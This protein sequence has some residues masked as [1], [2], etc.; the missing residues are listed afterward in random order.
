MTE[1]TA[2]LKEEFINAIK[3][4]S[5]HAKI[6]SSKVD[7][8]NSGNDWIKL[9]KSLKW[10]RIDYDG[11]SKNADSK[12]SRFIRNMELFP[13]FSISAKRRT[14]LVSIY[15]VV[16]SDRSKVETKNLNHYE[17][18][19]MSKQKS[20]FDYY[21]NEEN[22]CQVFDYDLNEYMER[23]RKE[24]G[25]FNIIFSVSNSNGTEEFLCENCNGVGEI[26]YS[27]GNYANG[28]P[29]IKTKTCP[30]C[31]G[32]GKISSVRQTVK[33]FEDHYDFYK[34]VLL[35]VISDKSHD[36]EKFEFKKK[37]NEKRKVETIFNFDTCDGYLSDDWLHTL[38]IS[39]LYQ[40]PNKII[41]DNKSQI[42][43]ELLA[44]GD[45]YKVLYNGVQ[46]EIRHMTKGDSKG[47]INIVCVLERHFTISPITVIHVKYTDS[48]NNDLETKFYAW[49][50]LLWCENCD[51]LS[52]GKLL[53]LKIKKAIS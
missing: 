26:E 12:D 18:D 8:N 31:G 38:Q 17:Y 43:N 36:D 22:L 27:A 25:S 32:K 48:Y 23:S 13:N 5:I 45:D 11:K 6:S 24:D 9:L 19:A 15:G 39:Q 46:N 29:R 37:S 10:K 40:A 28:E 52:F 53:L 4:S 41:I 7:V 34:E 47:D 44:L 51:E 42:E 49:E 2:Q 33:S 21:I 3:Y 16:S 1:L 50:N 30:V 14:A 35:N 20:D